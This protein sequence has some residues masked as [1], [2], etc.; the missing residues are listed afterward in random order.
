MDIKDLLIFKTLAQQKNI[1]K[2][3]EQ[4]NYVQS[5]VTARIKKLE[6]TLGTKLFYRHPR[7]VSLTGKGRI[8]LKKAEQILLLINETEKMIQD[9]DEPNGSLSLGTNETTAATRLPQLLVTYNKQYP[10][11]ELSLRVALT[12]ELIADVL[13]YKLDGAFVLGPIHDQQLQAIPVFQEELVIVSKSTALTDW[14]T[15]NVLT[16][17]CCPYK[18][19]LDQWL[20]TQGYRP[21]RIIEFGTLESIIHCVQAGLGM[22]I[23]PKS[24]VLKQLAEK[25]ITIHSLPEPNQ[26]IN[27]FFIYRK[28][29]Y[30]DKAYLAFLE[31]LQT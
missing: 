28:D 26:M 3:A 17:P 24:L 1:T 4:L 12:H 15:R 5:N 30:L 16:R 22:A 18:G 10:K 31:F 27:L 25:D 21:D 13:D 11:V 9:D 7:G 23:I 19:K 2:T 14:H 6:E 29:T 20:E 8:L